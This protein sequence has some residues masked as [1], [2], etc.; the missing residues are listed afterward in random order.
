MRRRG[1]LGWGGVGFGWAEDAFEAGHV[2]DDAQGLEFA[3]GANE[4]AVAGHDCGVVV[5]DD[6]VAR[7]DVRGIDFLSGVGAIGGDVDAGACVSG[8]GDVAAARGMR[9]RIA[10]RCSCFRVGSGDY[11]S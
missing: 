9:E 3:V 10:H 5:G 7:F 11:L 8:G 2:I 1:K 4:L 6:D